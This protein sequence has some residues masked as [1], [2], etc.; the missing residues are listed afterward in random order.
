[1]Y[2]TACRSVVLQERGTETPERETSNGNEEELRRARFET[3]WRQ[4]VSELY[5]R[6]LQ[7]TS[8]RRED[9]DDALGH[10]AL[11][12]LEKMPQ[13]LQPVEA[14]RWLLRLVYS[15]CM[16]IHRRRKRHVDIPSLEVEIQETG[17]GL[18]SVLLEGELL[19]VTRDRI[20]KLPPRLRSVAE[21][22]L[23]R[24]IPYS[25][26]ADL[27]VLTEVNVRKRMQEARAFLREPL[28][29]YLESDGPL[30]TLS[31]RTR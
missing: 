13:E 17:P 7:W 2:S 18:E 11:I 23:L 21:L 3:A 10:A 5:R 26:I 29:A 16:D 24:D 30:V 31:P 12:A 14:R 28:R 22:H 9:A 20:R 4:N 19:A 1:M 27:L 8:G 25:E 15:K 6:S